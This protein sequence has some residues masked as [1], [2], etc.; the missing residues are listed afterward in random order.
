MPKKN[1]NLWPVLLL[2]V[3]GAQT[4]E[5]DL[6]TVRQL[7]LENN[8]QMK[9]AEKS[10]EKA[11][12]Q[13]KEARA[14]LL[15]KV[16]AF[17]RYQRAWELPTIFFDN[18]AGPGKISFK[19]GSYHT[20]VSGVNIKQ[21]LFVGGAVWTGYQMNKLNAQLV[22]LQSQA[23]KENILMDA[24]SAYWGYL[25]ARSTVQVMEAALK[26]AQE[27]L[28]QVKEFQAAGKSSDFDVLRAEVQ[29]ATYQPQVISARNNA[30]LAESRLKMVMGLDETVTLVPRDSLVYRPNDW[31]GYSVDDLFRMA[32]ENRPEA[33]QIDLQKS[34]AKK[35]LVLARSSL[36]PALQFATDYQYQGERDN[37]QFTKDDFFKSFNSSLSLSIPLFNG[38]EAHSK[39]Q[40][41]KIGI[42]EV[43]DQEEAFLQGIRM[44]IESA[45]YTMKE[46][47]EKVTAQE[48]LV[49]QAQEAFRLAKLRYAEGASTQLEVMNAELALDQARMT[50]QQSLLEY[51]LALSGLEKAVNQL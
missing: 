10:R 50:Y 40:Q 48:K 16:S 32:V 4:L 44:E 30:R 20:L 45:Y 13:V 15:P 38:G 8:P 14:A 29:V 36:A 23:T 37:S 22:D 42:R 31:S 49:E 28:N 24:I 46:A 35:Q 3:L 39:I 6:A 5:V 51:N 19:M 34:L 43:E 18:P 9:L 25:F 7:A 27:N 47:E 2:T 41:A 17:S 26:T 12:A 11:Q 1:L 21:P 33:Q